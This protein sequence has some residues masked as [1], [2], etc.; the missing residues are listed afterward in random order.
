MLPLC[1]KCKMDTQMA[2]IFYRVIFPPWNE[3][4]QELYL[5]KC[6]FIYRLLSR[7]RRLENCADSPG[8]SPCP[9]CGGLA[10]S[11]AARRGAASSEAAGSQLE[12]VRAGQRSAVNMGPHLAPATI[13][14]AN[15]ALS[16]S[17]LS[18]AGRYYCPCSLT[19]VD[20]AIRTI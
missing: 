11:C 16:A 15:I 9:R 12:A 5:D 1:M 8:I 19:A 17:E 14:L 7:G 3:A 20:G 6:N 18:A 10:V 4:V 2:V 13:L